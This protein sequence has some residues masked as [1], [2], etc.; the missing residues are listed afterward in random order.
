MLTDG[1]DSA[2]IVLVMLPVSHD[3]EFCKDSRCSV[4]RHK[5]CNYKIVT[6]CRNCK[7]TLEHTTNAPFNY[8]KGVLGFCLSSITPIPY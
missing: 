1:N 8:T 2:T 6:R 4:E 3:N 7:S 5:Q